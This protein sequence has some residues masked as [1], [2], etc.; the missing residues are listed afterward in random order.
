[1]NFH[2]V[3][4]AGGLFRHVA[5]LQLAWKSICTV[6]LLFFQSWIRRR[7]HVFSIRNVH[8]KPG[9]I[10]LSLRFMEA[11]SFTCIIRS[12]GVDALAD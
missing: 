2:F 8:K 10:V 6:F 12:Q 9:H 4:L 7:D 3:Q 1:M 5:R 11:Y